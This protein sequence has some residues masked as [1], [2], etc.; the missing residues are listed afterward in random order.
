MQSKLIPLIIGCI[1]CAICVG[2]WSSTVPLLGG[3]PFT[4]G[5]AFVAGAGD[6]MWTT[7][8]STAPCRVYAC[9]TTGDTW[10]QPV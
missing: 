2:K 6:T 9:W 4:E 7:V 3:S 1:V 10:S 8:V 5:Q